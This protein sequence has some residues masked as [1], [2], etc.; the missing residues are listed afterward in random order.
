[1]VEEGKVAR[2]HIIP[3]EVSHLIV[4]DTVPKRFLLPL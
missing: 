2:L 4:S 1:M 3:H